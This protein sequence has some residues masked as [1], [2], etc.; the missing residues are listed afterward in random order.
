MYDIPH[1]HVIQYM[2][3]V[4]TVRSASPEPSDH[5]KG[6]LLRIL[7]V[8]KYRRESQF[9]STSLSSFRRKI[10]KPGG[11]SRS[12]SQNDVTIMF[13]VFIC[14]HRNSVIKLRATQ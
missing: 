4:F 1:R 10:C 2:L 13:F 3:L 6:G 5:T 9:R 11:Y 14:I 7:F 12:I 8:F